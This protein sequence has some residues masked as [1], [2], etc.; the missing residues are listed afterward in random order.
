MKKLTLLSAVA[1]LAL[2]AGGAFAQ[3]A[4]PAAPPAALVP[5]PAVP[6]A[7][8]ARG[9]IVDTLK[10]SGKFT[11]L[12]RTLDAT[13]LTSLL[14]TNKNLTLF[15]PTDAA[16]A[17]LPTGELAR[18]EANPTE[19]QKVLTFHLINASIDSSRVKGVKSGVA[20]VAGP[21][22][23]LDG[24]GAAMLAGNATVTQADVM[25]TNGIVHVVDKVLMPTG[26]PV[27]ANM[28]TDVEQGRIIRASYQQPPMEPA[29][30]VDPNAPPVTEASPVPPAPTPPIVGPPPPAAPETP[31]S[32][33]SVAT[34]TAET[35]TVT[36][37]PVLDTAENRAKYPPQSRAGKRTAAKG[38]R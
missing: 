10:A 6:G 25:A 18:L 13:N 27:A 38:N 33:A 30:P 15:A 31:T 12:V 5:A 36:N 29:D 26:T 1:S 32:V 23:T 11:V 28:T 24:S 37:G 22:I 35:A 16:F 21:Q 17:A 4:A 34:A 3:P 14:K 9:D 19:L 20:T 2:L 8:V 7:L